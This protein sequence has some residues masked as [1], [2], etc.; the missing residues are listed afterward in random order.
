MTVW[1]VLWLGWFAYFAVV[2]GLAIALAR[3]KQATL[4]DHVW[5]FLAIGKNL[6][7]H[8]RF[9]RIAFLSL[10]AWLIAHFFFQW[11]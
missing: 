9:R 8:V 7:R 2:E 11:A 4:S 6:D 5:S 10:T 3:D 1:T